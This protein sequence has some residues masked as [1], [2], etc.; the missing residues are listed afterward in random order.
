MTRDYELGF[1]LN[2][3]VN[4]DQTRSILDRVEQIVTSHDGQVIKVNQWGRRRMSYPIER[5]RDG[6]YI[7][8][9]L[10]LTAESVFELDRTLRVSEEVLRHLIKR[11]D[12]KSVQRE[13]EAR[14][15]NAAAIAAAAETQQEQPAPVPASD[16]ETELPPSLAPEE[17]EDVPPAIEEP[18]EIEEPV[19]R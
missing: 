13:R 8:I 11:R 2:P 15:A 12:P 16:E 14:A 1:I 4:E 10:I 3:E 17:I 7:F 5:H 9:D 19:E 6:F 18:I